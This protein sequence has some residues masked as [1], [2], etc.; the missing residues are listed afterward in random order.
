MLR[1][2]RPSVRRQPAISRPFGGQDEQ[3]I[4]FED[5]CAQLGTEFGERVVPDHDAQGLE[6]V[7][8]G[9]RTPQVVEEPSAGLA[10]LLQG[11]LAGAV[12]R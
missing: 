1:D 4:A 7:P 6:L 8:P 3:P 2:P 11:V 9:M 5:E 10:P 12:V